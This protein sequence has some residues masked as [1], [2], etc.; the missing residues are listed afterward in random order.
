MRLG[1]GTAP[2][3]LQALTLL[4]ASF[5]GPFRERAIVYAVA[6]G[7]VSVPEFVEA[8][9]DRGLDELAK[10]IESPDE[11]L[12]EHIEAWQDWLRT[13]RGITEGTRAKYRQ[14]LRE[15]MP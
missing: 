8:Y 7:E 1:V 2:P 9:E 15:F 14:Q 6:R 4:G 13:R 11:D 3:A 12:N 5:N 10:R